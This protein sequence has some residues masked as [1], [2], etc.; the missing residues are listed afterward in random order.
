MPLSCTFCDIF[1]IE[2][3][4]TLTLKSGSESLKTGNISFGRPLQRTVFSN[5]ERGAP[6][7]ICSA[8]VDTLR[9]SATSFTSLKT[10]VNGLPFV[11]SRIIV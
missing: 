10:I 1:D 7:E 9:V 8:G 3:K 6:V 11:E 5:A 4:S 2:K